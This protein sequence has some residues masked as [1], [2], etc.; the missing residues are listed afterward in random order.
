MS[1]G[2]R[3]STGGWLGR[4][5]L[6]VVLLGLYAPLAMV[7]VSS[8]KAGKL[9][10]DWTGVS[11]Q[12]YGALFHSRNLWHA[13]QASCTIGA[14]TSTLS[15]AAGTLAALGLASWRPR[16]R[17]AV[18]GLLA[19][20]LVVPD[21]ILAISLAIFFQA[22]HV[23]QGWSTVIL[24]HGVFGISY[25]YVVLAGAVDDLDDSLRL[26]ALDCGATPWQAFWRVTVP[27]LAPSLAVAWLLVFALS[28]DD[29]LITQMTKGPGSDTLP[30]K[31]YGQMRFGVRPE[32]SALFVVLFLAT[33]CGALLAGRLVRRRDLL[34]SAE[35]N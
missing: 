13:L 27:I 8:F 3:T 1:L 33:F 29:F 7:F 2:S 21:M 15:V 9:T 17:Q 5:L 19:L 26:A 22:L 16:P 31:I 24:A 18:Q 25:A 12:G 14:F 32:T 4:C 23:R 20:P 34:S 30:I 11:L 35:E 10:S 28:F 6:A